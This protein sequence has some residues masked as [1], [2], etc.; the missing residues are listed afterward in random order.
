[1]KLYNMPSSGNSYKV[2]LLLALTG[3]IATAGLALIEEGD[4]VEEGRILAELENDRERIQ[5]RKAELTL[6]D[7][8]RQL[9]RNREMLAEEQEAAPEPKAADE[10]PRAKQ[11][12]GRCGQGEA[13]RAE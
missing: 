1:M 13:R 4:W 10:A 7:N 11:G 5:L 6:A 12:R 9:E 8:A 3:A 2:R